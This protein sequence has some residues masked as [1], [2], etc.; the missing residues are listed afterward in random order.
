MK[1]GVVEEPK[2][3]RVLKVFNSYEELNADERAYWL[4][5]PASERWEAMEAIRRNV[6]GNDYPE[7]IQK[8]IEVVQRPKR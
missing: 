4:S 2:L 1:P 7:H 8:V 5:R 3:E 6:H